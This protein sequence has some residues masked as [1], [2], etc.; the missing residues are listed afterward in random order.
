MLLDFCPFTCAMCHRSTL[1]LMVFS[2]PQTF[3]EY[4]DKLQRDVPSMLPPP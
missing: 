4:I 2:T 1:T 3:Q